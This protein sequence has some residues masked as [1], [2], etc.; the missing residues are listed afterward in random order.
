MSAVTSTTSGSTALSSTGLNFTGL[1]TGI[2]TSKIIDGLTALNQKKIDSYK[3]QEADLA[4]KRTIFA[5]INTQLVS[6]QGALGSLSRAIGGAF[7]SSTVTASDATAVT[8]VSSSSA[9]PGAY[10]ITVNQLA[11]S[12]QVASSLVTT[13]STNIQ[14]GTVAIQSGSGTPI[15]VTI[16]STNNTLQGLATSI[17][18]ANGNVK[19]SV[20][21]DNN[22]YRLLLTGTQT[23]AA[24]AITV[25]SNLSGTGA[26]VNLSEKQVQVAKDSSVTLG[27]G[28]DAITVTSSINRADNLISGVSLNLLKADPTKSLT[29]NVAPDTDT[30]TKAVSSF[31]DSFNTVIDSINSQTKYDSATQTAGPLLGNSDISTLK[32]DLTS[33]IS[34]S[35]SGVNPAVNRMSSVGL[36][37]DSNG[38]LKFDSSK[39]TAALNGQV[40]GVSSADVKNLFAM[41]G[42]SS[43]S[44]ITFL[45]GGSKT[46]P[47][48]VTPTA[49]PYQVNISSAATQGSILATV[50]L[51]ASVVL[52]SANNTFNFRLNALT[53]ATIT[54]NPGTYDPAALAAA[55]QQQLNGRYAANSV[56]VDLDANRLRFTSAI[57]GSAS[58][59]ALSGGSAV[60]TLGFSGNEVGV[61]TNI[62]G[63]FTAGGK[64]ETAFGNGQI[65]SGAGDNA[66][67]AGLQVRVAL[68]ASQV[69]SG[70]TSASLTV[71]QGL[72]SRLS[73]MLDKYTDSSTGRFKTIDDRFSQSTATIEDTISRQNAQLTEKKNALVQQFADL[74]TSVSSLKNIG[75]TITASFGVLSYK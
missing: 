47:S 1:S 12:S 5:T 43:N 69:P 49:Q 35:V 38:K 61:G 25:T 42:T 74:E 54:L 19:A 31:V 63:S 66:N 48:P 53:T 67:T 37:I 4:N 32:T 46:K 55:I 10:S 22:G 29:I 64:T 56:S 75:N 11:Q 17:N 21:G 36:S 18:N 28:P 23:G 30:A 33:V 13:Q 71:T 8:G 50:A 65:L 26:T 3:A 34:G 2:D 62:S 57:Y 27:S 68:D 58:Q 72:A 9:I 41:S 45:L 16:D 40:T 60:S 20:V 7:Q 44:G 70:G 59:V 51:P 24:N 6:L 15:N 73:Q 52:T 14:T 39:L